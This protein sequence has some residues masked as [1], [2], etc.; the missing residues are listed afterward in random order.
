MNG[1][2]PLNTDELEQNLAHKQT[3]GRKNGR[4]YADFPARLLKAGFLC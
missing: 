3:R 1:W 4:I 2:R